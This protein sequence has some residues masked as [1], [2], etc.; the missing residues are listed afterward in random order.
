MLDKQWDIGAAVGFCP[1]HMRAEAAM[2]AMA[3]G[4]HLYCQKPLT[5]TVWEAS[6]LTAAAK[7]G[8]AT[9]M[10]DQGYLS[11]GIFLILFVSFT[12]TLF[13]LAS[14]FLKK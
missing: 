11:F 8:F 9:Q 12:F 5:G 1:G 2:W 7:H 3:R 14:M 4:K 13:F 10:G 6:Q